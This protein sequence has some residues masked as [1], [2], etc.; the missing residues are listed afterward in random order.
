MNTNT[1]QGFRCPNCGQDERFN[2]AA[3]AVVTLI[4]N[5]I[6]DQSDTEW[7]DESEGTCP[8][9][10]HSA[11]AGDF[12]NQ[13]TADRPG[14]PAQLLAAY[15]TWCAEREDLSNR[16]GNIGEQVSSS[17]WQASD[18]TAFDLLHR[19]A[20]VVRSAPNGE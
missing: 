11:R 4:D 13:P 17:E 1:L 20:T 2:V 16:D 19:F 10:G 15:E 12:F 18:D 9:C 8:D 6:E 7:D 3:I 5:G 14:T